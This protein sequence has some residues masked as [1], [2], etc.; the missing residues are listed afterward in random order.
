MAITFL[1]LY[2]EVASQPWSMFDADAESID[3]LEGSL[4]TSINKAISHLWNLQPW[5]FRVQDTKIR[6]ASGRNKIPMP[7]GK[8]FKESSNNKTT[9]G[10]KCNGKSLEYIAD[11]DALEEK[12]GTPEGFYLKG[13]NIYFYPTA[14]NTYTIDITYLMLPYALT[15]DGE[16]VY[17]L[18]EETDTLNIPDK[19]SALFR[20]CL[21]SLAMIYAIAD[22]NDE[23]HSGYQR[24]YEDALETLMDYCNT[25]LV[26]RILFW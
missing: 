2:N 1:E 5:S 7:N 12:T 14:D 6:L 25:P 26:D 8:L 21:I 15:E 17:E 10:I 20:N 11:Y 24:Q 16:E 23:N 13:E 18:K 9:Y 22:E 3:D 4:K 19:Y